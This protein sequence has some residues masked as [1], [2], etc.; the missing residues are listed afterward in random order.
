[1]DR[2]NL[3][4]LTFQ[5]FKEYRVWDSREFFY[6][7]TRGTG[8]DDLTGSFRRHLRKISSASVAEVLRISGL[9]ETEE[10]RKLYVQSLSD[11]SNADQIQ[12][13]NGKLII[14][15]YK[16]WNFASMLTIILLNIEISFQL[17]GPNYSQQQNLDGTGRDCECKCLYYA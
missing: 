6:K 16:K 1:M 17:E 13:E 7:L 8:G 11:P 15:Y 9:V 3:E 5:A 4:L 14:F 2:K 10:G 12:N